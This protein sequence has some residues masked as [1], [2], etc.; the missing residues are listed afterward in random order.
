MAR[1]LARPALGRSGENAAA[2]FYEDAGYDILDRNYRAGRGEIDLV[3]RR[4]RVV[5]FVEVKT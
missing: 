5:A 1:D 4:G 2:R 3:V